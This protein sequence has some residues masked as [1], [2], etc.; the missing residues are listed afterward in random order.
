MES[1]CTYQKKYQQTD[2]TTSQPTKIQKRTLEQ[3]EWVYQQPNPVKAS[4]NVDKVVVQEDGTV[5]ESPH[6]AE[7]G[8]VYN[9]A[10]LVEQRLLHRTISNAHV[11]VP[12]GVGLPAAQPRQGFPERG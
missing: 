5:T 8:Y 10:K 6:K 4:L 2:S 11:D 12:V 7:S 1:K 9:R 3:L